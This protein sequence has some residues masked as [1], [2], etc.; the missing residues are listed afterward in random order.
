MAFFAK[1]L[2]WVLAGAS[3]LPLLTAQN[4]SAAVAAEEP[5][6]ARLRSREATGAAAPASQVSRSQLRNRLL[7]IHGFSLAG[8]AASEDSAEEISA[9]L[10][11]FI[12][13]PAEPLVVKRQAIKALAS[14]PTER[15]FGFIQHRVLDA[16]LALSRLYVGSLRSFAATRSREITALLETLLA[17]PEVSLRHSA[18]RL[19]ASLPESSRLG[20]LLR[21]R[22]AAEPEN[23]VRA[24]L[25]R[26]LSR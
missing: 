4:H 8:L 7:S 22:P 25:L 13:G 5:V 11:E 6:E 10:R 20:A 21:E 18:A 23:G 16:P 14:F 3:L 15:N 17:S 1:A 24:E 2:C 19:A 12:T 26:V 9:T